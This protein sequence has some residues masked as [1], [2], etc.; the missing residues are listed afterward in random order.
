MEKIRKLKPEGSF[1]APEEEKGLFRGPTWAGAPSVSVGLASQPEA[2]LGDPW[3][4]LCLPNLLASLP[5]CG[6]CSIPPSRSRVGLWRCKSQW[7]ILWLDGHQLTSGLK[8][9]LGLRAVALMPPLTLQP[10]IPETLPGAPAAGP[11]SVSC[12]LEHSPV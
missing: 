2:L 9:L 11:C 5:G 7:V 10:T 4:R 3:L 12:G 8:F 6:P 1:V